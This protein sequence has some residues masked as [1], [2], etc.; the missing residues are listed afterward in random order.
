MAVEP[1]RLETTPLN[2]ETILLAEKEL[3]ETPEIRE[4]AIIELRR[5]LSENKDLYYCDDEATLLVFLRPT[6]F[7]PESA[8]KL[9]RRIAEFRVEYVKILKNLV[10]DDEKSSFVDNNVV[11][12][13]TNLDQDGRRVLIVN[14]GGIW[15]TKKVS[16]DSL[17]RIFY[18]IHVAAQVEPNTQVRGVVVI[19][20]FDGLGLSQVRALSPSF[21]KRLLTFIQD[22]MPIRMKAVHIINQ[23]YVF[24]MVWKLFKPFIREKLGSRMFLHGKDRESLHKHMDPE[25]LPQNYGGRLPAINYSGKDWFPSVSDHLDYIE[26]WNTFG[27]VNQK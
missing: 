12:V 7:Y 20:D 26:R 8:I 18:L 5:L 21:S 15:D 14:C 3:R 19:M 1:F 4:Q 10:P 25:Y 24:N 27:F 6:H 17:F 2:E 23:P 22:A 16:A 13:L 11:N 9:M